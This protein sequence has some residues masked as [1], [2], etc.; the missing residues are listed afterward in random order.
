MKNLA[1]VTGLSLAGA[2]SSSFFAPVQA[3]SMD[4]SLNAAFTDGGTLTGGFTYDDAANQ[5]TN[6][7]LTATRGPG[8][9]PLL[10]PNFTYE[11]VGFNNIENNSFL[12]PSASSTAFTLIQRPFDPDNI[13]GLN[14]VFESALDPMG[15]VAIQPS[16][17]AF[18][19]TPSNEVAFLSGF[20]ANSRGIISGD[21][22]AVPEPITL[23]GS[24]VALA[25]GAAFERRRKKA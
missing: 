24:G 12:G 17:G 25:F 16:T 8:T 22:T 14:L 10:L 11:Y 1:L 4:Y 7:S 23:L 5:Y 20:A 19:L 15:S 3:V 9:P 2:L 6:I 13:R 18:F 21:V